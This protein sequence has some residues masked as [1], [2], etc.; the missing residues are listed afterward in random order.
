MGVYPIMYAL[1]NIERAGAGLDRLEDL[2]TPYGEEWDIDAGIP[3]ITREFNVAAGL[4]GFVEGVAWVNA[5]PRMF[6]GWYKDRVLAFSLGH[7]VIPFCR[8]LWSDLALKISRDQQKPLP[9]E[10][11][12]AYAFAEIQFPGRKWTEDLPTGLPVHPVM[13]ALL[14]AIQPVY[15]LVVVDAIAPRA[16]QRFNPSALF[17]GPELL[18]HLPPDLLSNLSGFGHLEMLGE[19][20]WATLPGF[21][22]RDDY[23]DEG[24]MEIEDRHM[25]AMQALTAALQHLPP[26]ALWPD[27]VKGREDPLLP[28]PP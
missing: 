21:I 4:R 25:E 18:S 19:G 11:R 28:S 12:S 9:P 15:A 6:G 10:A 14:W 2:Q 26:E 1:L 27:A 8:G 22:H 5:A 24:D 20:L 7:P 23:G 13:T 17:L 16:F 3:E